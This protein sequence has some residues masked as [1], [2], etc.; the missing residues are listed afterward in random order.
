MQTYIL[1]DL[2]NL[3][4]RAKHVTRG[5]ASIKI[6][7]SMH[8]AFSSILS[9]WKKFEA[10]H[11]VICLDGRSWRREVYDN[12]KRSRRIASAAKSVREQAEDEEFNEAFNDLIKFLQEKTNVSVLKS[13]GLEADDLVA[14]WIAVH[15]DSKHV[16]ISSDSDFYQLLSSNVEIYNGITGMRITSGGVYNDKD[17]NME[18]SVK[19]D[20][21]IK[22]GKPDP[23]FEPEPEW[24]EWAKFSKMM[25]GD[26]GDGILTAYAKVRQTQLQRAYEDPR[27][28][29]YI[30]NNLMLQTWEDH[31]GNTR[32]VLDCYNENRMLIDL[33]ELPNEIC[34]L[35]DTV[36]QESV[37]REK[38]P[39]IGIWFLRF[40]N[41]HQ[42]V[43]IEQNPNPH[44]E[45]LQAPYS[46]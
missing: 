23:N 2:N 6:G 36:I 27:E 25:R 19:N 31:E 14:R 5:D 44:L 32:R 7:L 13:P 22:I 9:M 39:Q 43:R 24:W 33:T 26:A 18:F 4:H 42:L 35:A 38:R 8:I 29:A 28:R 34:T 46:E 15:P 20:G 30:W 37:Q 11:V 40:C 45:Y 1:I 16:I 3:L 41:R 10:S 12:Y 17:K 21:K